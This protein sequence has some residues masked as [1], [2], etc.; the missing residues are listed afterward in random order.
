MY[1]K[2][3][4]VRGGR[5]KKER[6]WEIWGVFI[7]QDAA[8]PSYS[9]LAPLS[10]SPFTPRLYTSVSWY[11]LHS[12]SDFTI[13][14]PSS[15]TLSPLLVLLHSSF[16]HALHCPASIEYSIY[17]HMIIEVLLH[18]PN[19]SVEFLYGRYLKDSIHSQSNL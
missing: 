11:L 17:A 4:P 3:K 13:R 15:F 19:A 1:D 5:G 7:P 8:D 18:L 6:R 16:I 14:Q 10:L 2:E 9:P 12:F